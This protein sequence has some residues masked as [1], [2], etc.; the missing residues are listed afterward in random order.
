MARPR[1]PARRPPAR[2][3]PVVKRSTPRYSPTRGPRALPRRCARPF[4][5]ETAGHGSRNERTAEPNLRQDGEPSI[6]A[7]IKFGADGTEH[8]AAARA[9]AW[10]RRD[11][12]RI[13]RGRR[14]SRRTPA[15]DTGDA[16]PGAERQPLRPD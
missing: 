1:W 2:T 5:L 10:I 16:A 3:V 13:A 14:G 11:D 15:A 4:S 7:V 8:C 12:R 9:S 6:T